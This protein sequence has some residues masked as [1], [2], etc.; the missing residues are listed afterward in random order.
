MWLPLHSIIK[1]RLFSHPQITFIGKPVDTLWEWRILI[2]PH[3]KNSAEVKSGEQG[4]QV[5]SSARP[6][7]IHLLGNFSFSHILM[8]FCK[9]VGAL[10]LSWIKKSSCAFRRWQNSVNNLSCN[11]FKYEF[12]S[13]FSWK[14]N[15]PMTPA[16][17]T[18]VQTIVFE[19]FNDFSIRQWGL[20]TEQ[21]EIFW[22]FTGLKLLRQKT[23][24]TRWS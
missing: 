10:P 5:K 16:F 22:M 7:R 24:W 18:I 17:S 19:E 2:L 9:R 3:M 14:K 20:V 15:V 13:T 1:F 23:T 21:W 8:F 6:R 4:D 12:S 11:I